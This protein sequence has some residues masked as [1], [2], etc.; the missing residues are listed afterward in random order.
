MKRELCLFLIAALAF[1]MFAAFP[2]LAYADPA[3]FSYSY[4]VVQ[5]PDFA[6]VGNLTPGDW[7]PWVKVNV[8]ISTGAGE[9]IT[10]PVTQTGGWFAEV[11]DSG[12]NKW[13]WPVEAVPGPTYTWNS[14]TDT[15]T[16]KIRVQVPTNWTEE[17]CVTFNVKLYQ[18]YDSGTRPRKTIG[19]GDGVHFKVCVKIPPSAHPA[20]TVSI[21]KT[22]NVTMA[23]VG[24]VIEYSF[25]VTN[26]GNVNLTGVYIDDNLTGRID[27]G[28]LGQGEG[29]VVKA[30]HTVSG[31][32]PDPLVNNATV[33]AKYDSTVV[34][35]WDTWTVDILHPAIEVSKSGP[36]YAHEGDNI[37]YTITVKNTGDCPLSNVQVS[38]DVAGAATYVSGDTNG[39]GLLDMDETWTFTATYTVKAGDTDPLVNTATAS[40]K[41]ALGLTVTDTASWTV[42]ILHPAIDVIKSANATKAYA[43]DIIEYTIVVKN[44]GDCPL[45]NVNVTDTFL[46][47][48]WTGTLDVGENKTFTLTYTVK[49]GD[50]DPLVNTA[51]ASGKDVLGKMV[52]DEDTATVDLIAKICGYKF[53]DANANGMLDNGEMGLG[54]WTIQLFK[55]NGTAWDWV[56]NATTGS[57]GSYCFDGLDAGEY[58]VK[59]VAQQYWI[60]TTSSSI[61]V[62]LKSG[63]ISENNNFGNVCL[64]QGTGGKTLGYWANA[65]NKLITSDDVAA[66]N[67]LNLHK[68]SGWNYPP[69]SSTLTTAKSQISSYLLSANAKDMRWMLSAQLIATKL[70]V[71]H[72]SLS[73]STIVYV[74]PSTYVPSGFISI[75]DIMANANTALSGADRATQ[76][77]WKNLLDGLNNNRLPFVC[78]GPCYPIV[79]P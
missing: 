13:N 76:E 5:G 48:I 10:F 54:G 75:D 35:A 6:Y 45:Y 22:A 66:L 72:G 64:K 33:Y 60:C 30:T 46:G 68:P 2:R 23:H 15:V 58:M 7:T 1:S 69:F 9:T 3:N 21:V 27:I 25:Y 67:A 56:A 29:T 51:T 19:S 11:S 49:V 24:D 50:P 73:G 12:G 18:G 38:D 14:T 52:T 37:T 20:A 42:D 70:N 39:N 57:D 34:Y 40:G 77:Y 59:E 65:G 44:T 47:D 31:N 41:D 36:E 71:L 55:W 28:K 78:P 43:G 62:D 4:P 79:Y 17:G 61:T 32:D 74:G 16:V 26:T 63:E 53:Y 8:T